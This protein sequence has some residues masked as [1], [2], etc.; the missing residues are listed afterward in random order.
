M[1]E[2]VYEV[3][4]ELSCKEYVRLYFYSLDS[5]YSIPH[6]SSISP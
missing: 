2:R 3:Q 6:V 4:I 5:F 1:N